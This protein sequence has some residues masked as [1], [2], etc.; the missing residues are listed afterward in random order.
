MRNR[1]MRLFSGPGPC[2]GYGPWAGHE[3]FMDYGPGF[4]GHRHG[5]YRG[6]PSWAYGQWVDDGPESEEEDLRAYVGD[7]ESVVKGLQDEI[8]DLKSGLAQ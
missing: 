5:T 8:R 7:L 6:G 3:R 2:C 4:H 1:R